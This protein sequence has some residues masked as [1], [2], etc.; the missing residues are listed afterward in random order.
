MH[1]C[2]GAGCGWQNIS[3]KGKEVI[4]CWEQRVERE[5]NICEDILAALEILLQI[6]FIECIYE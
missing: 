1:L 5:K 3:H 6:Y 2:H 4:L